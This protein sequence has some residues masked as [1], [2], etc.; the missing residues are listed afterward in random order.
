MI[1]NQY[2]FYYYKQIQKMGSE[3][4][5]AKRLIIKELTELE[6]KRIRFEIKRTNINQSMSY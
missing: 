6:S 3:K 4:S 2:F 5:H 1:I